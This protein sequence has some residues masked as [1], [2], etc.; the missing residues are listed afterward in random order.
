MDSSSKITNQNAEA[1]LESA[2]FPE[3]RQALKR[4]LDYINDSGE[5][6]KYWSIVEKKNEEARK[7]ARRLEKDRKRI[8]MGSDYVTSDEDDSMDDD[9]YD[10]S[11]VISLPLIV[12]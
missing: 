7:A 2:L 4:L 10:E 12:S 9:D 8:E 11:D 1:Y 3:V 6:E 5:L